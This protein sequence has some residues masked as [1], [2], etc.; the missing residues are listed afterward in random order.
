V[1]PLAVLVSAFPLRFDAV[2]P[3]RKIAAYRLGINGENEK[4]C[5]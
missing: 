4:G 5:D 2:K 3:L 1:K